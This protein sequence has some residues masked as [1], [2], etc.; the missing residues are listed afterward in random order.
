MWRWI[1]KLLKF[2]REGEPSMALV[3]E[4]A[5][6]SLWWL[7]DSPLFID[8]QLVAGFYDALV[9]P[10]FELQGKTIGEITEKTNSLLLGGGGEAE[11]GLP[12]FLSVL[13]K[14]KIDAKVENTS[15]RSTQASNAYDLKKVKTAGR[16]LEELVAVYVAEQRYHDR[17]LF[18]ECPSRGIKTL[19]GGTVEYADFSE[20][21]DSFPRSLVFLEVKPGAAILPMMC[22]F[23]G[24]GFEPLYEKLIS[25]LWGSEAG[26]P[27]YPRESS[28]TASEE[29]RVYW[30]ALAEKYES[31]TAMEVLEAAMEDGRKLDWVDFRLSLNSDGDTVHLHAC[32]R[33]Q[34]SAGTF[35]YNFIRRGNRKGVRIV[36]SLKRGPDLNVLAIFEC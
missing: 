23:S 27:T 20:A 24:G 32:P 29:R 14:A 4:P 6:K 19:A 22:E 34:Y 15:E 31:R 36:G 2:K 13:G 30:K 9:R 35:G 25:K 16:S 33:G 1:R 7:A 11:L 21:S 28:P 17:L 3:R 10:E 8:E 26:R 12:S 5:L 18:M